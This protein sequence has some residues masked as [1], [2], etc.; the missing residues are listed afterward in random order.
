MSKLSI[1]VQPGSYQA[2][3]PLLPTR[4]QR[5]VAPTGASLSVLGNTR[6]A[7]RYC[8][9]H[10]E[11]NPKVVHEV[12]SQP[13]RYLRWAGADLIHATTPD[14][15]RRNVVIEVNS[16]PSGQKSMPLRNEEDERG[17]LLEI[18]TSLLDI[19]QTGDDVAV[20]RN[21]FGDEIARYKAPHTGVVI[22]HSV[23]PVTTTGG[24]ILHLGVLASKTEE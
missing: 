1:W 23:N 8:H 14:G 15:V 19:V 11:A 7:Q 13:T 9:L 20:L 5:A 4:P 2:E 17:G 21:P 10:P 3:K 22:G 6:I 16:S 18:L 12:L 24:R